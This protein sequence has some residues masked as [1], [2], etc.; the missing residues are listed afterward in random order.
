MIVHHHKLM[1]INTKKYQ[2]DGI[3]DVNNI[4]QP[5]NKVINYNTTC[6]YN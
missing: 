5:L 6:I 1:S 3:S 2:I 4:A